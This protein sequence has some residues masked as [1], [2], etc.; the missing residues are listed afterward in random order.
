[1]LSL[2]KQKSVRSIKSFMRNSTEFAE[3]GEIAS[4]NNSISRYNTDRGYSNE[5]QLRA[6]HLPGSVHCSDAISAG[7]WSWIHSSAS[8]FVDPDTLH[9]AAAHTRLF[10]TDGTPL[11]VPFHIVSLG[12]EIEDGHWK[13]LAGARP[14]PGLTRPNMSRVAS[15]YENATPGS[16]LRAGG[17][18]TRRPVGGVFHEADAGPAGGKVRRMYLQ[19]DG[20]RLKSSTNAQAVICRV[21][22]GNQRP[23]TQII[24]LRKEASKGFGL[25]ANPKE[26]FIFDIDEHEPRVLIRIHATPVGATR[27]S[28]DGLSSSPSF[29]HLASPVSDRPRLN[30]LLSGLRR[31]PTSN[32]SFRFNND[33]FYNSGMSTPT[34]VLPSNATVEAGP[35]LGEIIFTV[36]EHAAY[37]H[38][39][40][41][42]EYTVMSANAKKEIAKLSLQ[43]GTFLDEEY[44]PEPEPEPIPLEPDFGDYLN[45]MIHTAGVSVWRKYWCVLADRELCVYD[46]EY[47]DIKPISR[48]PL[49]SIS[50]VHPADAE[51]IM[52]PYCIELTLTPQHTSHDTLP[53]WTARVIDDKPGSRDAVVYATAESH[54]AMIGWMD[55]IARCKAR[56]AGAGTP[57]PPPRKGGVQKM[58]RRKPVASMA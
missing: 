36:P 29:E 33:A 57:V 31:S 19:F 23:C 17:K 51:F 27:T 54:E 24:Y 47:R 8:G 5:P 18:V 55:R 26:G 13:G 46:F 16:S 34:R 35:L 41:A 30:N 3:G 9:V 50:Q 32:S 10:A 14:L 20:L 39:K 43:L 1:M 21:Q 58:E 4:S 56:L 25:V 48:L 15:T 28:L 53:D 49:S 38:S 12:D 40:V 42:G 7:I 37:N 6:L 52:A 2:R 45:F 11:E 44:V 22:C